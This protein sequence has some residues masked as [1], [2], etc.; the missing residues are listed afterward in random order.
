MRILLCDDDINAINILSKLVSEYYETQTAID[1]ELVSY[2]DGYMLLDDDG[3]IDLLFLDIE[4]PDINGLQVGYIF[5]QK[6]PE[7]YIFVVSSYM[8]YLDDAMR[9]HVYRYLSKPIDKQRLFRNLNDVLQEIEGRDKQ[10][11]KIITLTDNSGSHVIRLTD[12]VFV[13]SIDHK[14]IVHTISDEYS[15]SETMGYWLNR[16]KGYSFYQTNRSFIVNM[17]YVS[18]YNRSTVYLCKKKFS[19]LLTT[20]KYAGFKKAFHSFIKGNI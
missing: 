15:T 1:L 16:L 4:M 12:I 11:E 2:N 20:R 10:R 7:T 19:V 5:A 13:E 17:A 18:D 9:F 14:T 3:D 6:H 8:E